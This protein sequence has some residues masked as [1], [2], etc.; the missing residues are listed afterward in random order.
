VFDIKIRAEK[1][2]PFSQMSMNETAKELYKLGAFNP[3]KATEALIMLDMMEFEGIDSV[4]EKV[5][6]GQTLLSICR[7][8]SPQMDQMA[9]IIQAITGKDMGIASGESAAGA[10]S[11]KAAST[12]QGGSKTLASTAQDSRK[13][14]MTE[15]GDRLA[16][17]AVPNMDIISNRATPG[18]SKVVTVIARELSGRRELRME[19]HAGYNAGNDIVCAGCSALAYAL[20]GWIANNA[21]SVSV[22]EASDREGLVTVCAS[23][24]ERFG[25][26]FDTAVIGLSQIAKRYPDNVRVEWS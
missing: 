22:D 21:E 5:Q 18:G 3:E 26:A 2:N 17:R 19:G 9:A 6:Q 4:R 7:Q 23:G 1:R 11:G 13:Q 24:D 8:M 12:P 15:Y 20:L 25:A 10:S 14:A 16:K